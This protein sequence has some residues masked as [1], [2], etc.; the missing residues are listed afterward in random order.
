MNAKTSWAQLLNQCEFCKSTTC[1][2]D[3][4]SDHW[5]GCGDCEW[6][7]REDIIICRE[8]GEEPRDHEPELPAGEYWIGDPCYIL[9]ESNGFDWHDVLLQTNYLQ[10]G[11]KEHPG[12]GGLFTYSNKDVDIPIFSSNTQWGDGC[13]EDQHGNQY[14]VDAGCI[15]CIPMEILTSVAGVPDGLHL[16]HIHTMPDFVCSTVNRAGHITFGDITIKTG[17]R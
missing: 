6:T 1:D 16:G 14:G 9:T 4:L 7:V 5:C 13:Y 17:G 10:G 15:A 11:T 2:R 8:C 12:R 3:C